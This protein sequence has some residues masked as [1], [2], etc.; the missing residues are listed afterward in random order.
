MHIT[1]FCIVILLN[2]YKIPFKGL[3]VNEHCSCGN[4]SE[5]WLREDSLLKK[6]THF[7]FFSAISR[8]SCGISCSDMFT[9]K[10]LLFLVLSS[11]ALFA[12]GRSIPRGGTELDHSSN[13]GFRNDGD[14]TSIWKSDDGGK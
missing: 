1:L 6:F 3:L 7:D 9:S 5:A 11:C 4:F 14:A 8:L 12:F 2:N 10:L 13:E